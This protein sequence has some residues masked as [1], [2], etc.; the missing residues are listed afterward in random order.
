MIRD[1]ILAPNPP[2]P[3]A[4]QIRSG[5]NV[6]AINMPDIPLP[7]M[8]SKLLSPASPASTHS[9]RNPEIDANLFSFEKK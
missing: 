4:I 5:D 6:N 1:P 8:I 2:Y 3:I 7:V 9:V